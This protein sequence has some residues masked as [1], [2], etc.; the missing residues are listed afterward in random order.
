MPLDIHTVEVPDGAQMAMPDRMLTGYQYGIAN[1][2]GG[3]AGT[4]VT[5]AVSGFVN[6]PANYFVDVDVSQPCTAN[7]TGK[8]STGFNVV[9]TPNPATATLAAGTFNVRVSA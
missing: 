5:T 2:S 7:V 9:L 8:T 4:A 3:T 6:L 1:A